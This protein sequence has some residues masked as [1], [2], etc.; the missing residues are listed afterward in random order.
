MLTEKEIQVLE[1]R[2]KGLTQVDVAKKLKITQAAVSNF[3]KNAHRKIISAKE[4][5]EVARRLGIDA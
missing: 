2:N 4:T 3:E 1:L 5:V